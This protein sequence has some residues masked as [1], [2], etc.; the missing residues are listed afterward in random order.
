MNNNSWQ[1]PLV[2]GGGVFLALASLFLL[3]LT[4]GTV[5]GWQEN[6]LSADAKPQITVTG[7][8]EMTA[9]PDVASFTFTVIE[10]G[11]TPKIAQDKATEKTNKALAYLKDA[12]IEEKDIKTTSYNI[13]PQYEYRQAS[14]C[15]SG[16]CAPGKQVLIGYEVLQ[17]VLVKVKDTAQAGTILGGIGEVGVQNVSGLQMTFNDDEA[18]MREARKAAIEDAKAKAEILAND[19]GVRLVRITSFVESGSG[20]PYPMP[21]AY[22]SK[23]MNQAMDARGAAPSL[24]AGENKVN[25]VVTITYEIR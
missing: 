6:D 24:P 1:R 19:L 25:T 3:V 22:E 4:V 16:Y 10:T 17:S 21:A 8:G 9:V 20:M 7:E 18:I 13:N 11:A 15:V 5:R 12:K 23:V 14:A 2:I